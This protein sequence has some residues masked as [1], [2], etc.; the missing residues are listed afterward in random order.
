MIPIRTAASN[1]VYRGPEPGIEDAWVERRP[2]ERAVYLTWRP[3]DAERE[4]IAAGA[5]IELGIHGLEP[6]PPVSLNV[7]DRTEL[8]SE[9]ALLRDRARAVLEQLGV[10]GPTS[11]PPGYWAVAGDIWRALN[12][13]GALDPG[14]GLPT[15]LG[16]P[17]ME[18]PAAPDGSIE[19]VAGKA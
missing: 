15:L 3:S 4:A 5:L 10:K 17:L 16:R 7:S 13:R 12:D 2:S 18:M 6:I 9:G 1:F 14:G 11:I 19:Y 8:S